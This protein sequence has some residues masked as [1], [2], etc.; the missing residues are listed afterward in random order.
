MH[1]YF[2]YFALCIFSS[3]RISRLKSV[4]YAQL[5]QTLFKKPLTLPTPRPLP[6]LWNNW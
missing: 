4:R 1:I 3:I 5:N 2:L 6:F